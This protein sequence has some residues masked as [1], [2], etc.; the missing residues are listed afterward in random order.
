MTTIKQE[1]FGQAFERDATRYTLSSGAVSV[2]VS[3]FGCCI[4]D[5]CVRDRLG[6]MRNVV[7]GYA[8][9]EGYAAGSSCLGA[10][11]GRYAGRIGKARFCLD[12]REFTLEKNDGDNH[13]HGGFSKRFWHAEQRRGALELRLF[14]PD[15][16]EGFPGGLFVCVTFE[17]ADNVLR[18]TYEAEAD[19]D[20]VLNLTNHSYFNLN[21]GGDALSHLLCVNADEYAEL[22]EGMIPTGRLL[23]TENTPLDF[24]RWRLVGSALEDDSL[25]STGGMDHSF[26]LLN[27]GR[28]CEAARL[29]SPESGVGLIC[30][31]TQPTV[32]I[33]TG[34]YLHLDSAG[35]DRAGRP[36]VKHGGI[37][38]E[39]QHFPDSPNRPEFPSAVL[40]AGERYAEVTEYEVWTERL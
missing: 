40:R 33:Y 12:G 15:G 21:G 31:T 4:T 18:I 22:G 32:H 20:T 24:A 1:I 17:L 2:G 39:T 37:C 6:G 26:A 10:T 8:S 30:R 27:E 7:A 14:S 29:F 34:N 11:V 36:L 13:L 19:A 25:L 35:F 5:L 16:D 9:A 38:L 3:D 23:P 28:L